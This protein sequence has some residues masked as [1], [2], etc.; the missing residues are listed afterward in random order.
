[1]EVLLT[2]AAQVQ[3]LPIRWSDEG[4]CKK[5]E[6]EVLLT[7]TTQVQQFQP[8]GVMEVSVRS[9]KRMSFSHLLLKFNSSI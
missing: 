9:E 8:G 1:V 3:Q 5:W 4:L 6:E 7:S 2:S